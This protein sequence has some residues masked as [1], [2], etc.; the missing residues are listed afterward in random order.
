MTPTSVAT[1]PPV[2]SIVV[3]SVTVVSGSVVYPHLV[4]PLISSAFTPA[5]PSS[6]NVPLAFVGK[7]RSSLGYFDHSQMVDGF[8]I[9]S[10]TNE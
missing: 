5:A 3:P 10:R 1:Q 2:A 8:V 4:P 7:K 9:R 6:V